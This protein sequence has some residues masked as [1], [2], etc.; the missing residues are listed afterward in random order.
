ML[1]PSPGIT[2][3]ASVVVFCAALA[4]AEYAARGRSDVP[5]EMVVA[6]LIGVLAIGLV[7]FG[8]IRALDVQAMFHPVTIVVLIGAALLA[9]PPGVALQKHYGEGTAPWAN[10]VAP[11]GT[12][13]TSISWSSANGRF[14]ETLNRRFEIELTEEQY[15]KAMAQH[16]RP[17][18]AAGVQFGYMMMIVSFAMVLLARRSRS[19]G[20]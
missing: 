1:R 11:D 15:R 8:R 4:V 19:N 6:V 20:I 16:Y 3:L 2:A 9:G 18:I 14:T 7:T 5:F 17:F 13:V 12:P 10:R